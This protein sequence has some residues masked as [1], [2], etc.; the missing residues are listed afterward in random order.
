MINEGI[1]EMSGGRAM[2]RESGLDMDGVCS[3]VFSEFM[4][5]SCSGGCF[6]LSWSHELM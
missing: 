2:S 6:R 3:D 1:T 4:S 5:Q